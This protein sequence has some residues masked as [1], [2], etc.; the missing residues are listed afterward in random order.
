MKKIFL[1]VGTP[2]SGK[3]YFISHN[4]DFF[5]GSV[6]VISR[7]KIRFALLED[8]EDYFAKE[9]DVWT[10]F[11]REVADGLQ[12]YDNTVVDATHLNKASRHKILN[13]V[14]RY[15]GGVEINAIFMDTCLAVAL[16]QNAERTGRKC[17]PISALR[18]MAYQLT[19]P[20][21][22]EGF[23]NIYRVKRI[24]DEQYVECMDDE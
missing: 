10:N 21:K 15:L 20:T 4:R 19:V 3:S 14:G 13:A 1:M 24:G 2:G 8:G 16:K 7:D 22:E 18:R 12:N 11:V 5:K 23:N 17:V 6:K 9:D